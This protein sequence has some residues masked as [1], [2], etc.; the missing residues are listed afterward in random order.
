[1]IFALLRAKKKNRISNIF[2]IHLD[3]PILLDPSAKQNSSK[4]SP[5]C[6]HPAV[7]IQKNDARRNERRENGKG[8][9]KTHPLVRGRGLELAYSP[10]IPTR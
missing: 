2:R 6:Y 3:N 4:F 1:M 9:N 10:S 7:I 8:F 5:N